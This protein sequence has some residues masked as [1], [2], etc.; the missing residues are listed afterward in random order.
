M[1][2]P[3]RSKLPIRVRAGEGVADP[4]YLLAE[5]AELGEIADRA[6]M[7]TLAY[8]LECARLECLSLVKQQEARKG[9]RRS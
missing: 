3:R 1:D 2:E 5:I 7:G 9:N 4:G 6:G 8:A